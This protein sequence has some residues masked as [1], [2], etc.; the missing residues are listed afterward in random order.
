MSG[1]NCDKRLTLPVLPRLYD[2]IP[3]IN[4]ASGSIHHAVFRSL[5]IGRFTPPSKNLA[6]GKVAYDY[7]DAC[8]CVAAWV[9]ILPTLK[10][11]HAL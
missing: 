7:F 10:G 6:N 4:A 9:Q 2:A 3:I 8:S 1:P 5:S 11:H